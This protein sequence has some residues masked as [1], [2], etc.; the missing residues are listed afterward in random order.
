MANIFREENIL[1]D[2]NLAAIAPETGSVT[3]FPA[4]KLVL[5]SASK[6]LREKL[7]NQ[8]KQVK[9]LAFP[10]VSVI[11]L[12]GVLDFLYGQN[13]LGDA[14]LYSECYKA[15]CALDIMSAK[16]VFK[17]LLGSVCTE[18]ELIEV[19]L[20]LPNSGSG[21]GSDNGGYHPSD[22]V[23]DNSS[24]EGSD[25]HEREEYGS[26]INR[27]YGKNR[28]GKNFV[29]S[30]ANGNENIA[31]GSKDGDGSFEC[32]QVKTEENIC[33]MENQNNKSLVQDKKCDSTNV[34]SKLVDGKEQE[35]NTCI[36][37]GTVK[38][39]EMQDAR[40]I[41]ESAVGESGEMQDRRSISESAVC[42][43]GEISKQDI[44]KSKG[45]DTSVS[46]THQIKILKLKDN[47]IGSGFMQQKRK[48][49]STED[50]HNLVNTTMQSSFEDNNRPESKKRVANYIFC[51]SKNPNNSLE[52]MKISENKVINSQSFENKLP[53][54]CYVCRRKTFTALGNIRK[55]EKNVN[56]IS[57]HNKTSL[58]K[59]GKKGLM[60][61]NRV[62]VLKRCKVCVRKLYRGFGK[63]SIKKK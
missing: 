58:L 42:E 47:T 33:S 4:H 51:D 54:T 31:R 43:S 1:C 10:N 12:K 41:S 14:G 32:N 57:K 15:A 38:S 28:G 52:N 2:I 35:S 48:R 17:N 11:G 49:C 7:I 59:E 61:R 36:E 53:F 46:N 40:S 23:N 30:A 6:F 3:K 16:V 50:D 19:V 20:G 37:K 39:N 13:V 25:Y 22:L 29:E 56:E 27:F 45:P 18:E 5:I 62:T 26:N 55:L 60:F 21:F 9:V 63:R 24:L 44:D 34:V 8:P